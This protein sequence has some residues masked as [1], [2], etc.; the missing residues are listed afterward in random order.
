[1]DV[2][3]NTFKG[4]DGRVMQ[5]PT[6]YVL[7]EKMLHY[8]EV[9][10]PIDPREM[11]GNNKDRFDLKRAELDQQDDYLTQLFLKFNDY[12]QWEQPPV[13]APAPGQSTL[14]QAVVP[15]VS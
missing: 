6:K 1:M 3:I 13:F 5:W 10:I 11:G 8:D 2:E 7:S 15:P 9:N 12:I 14:S 4:D